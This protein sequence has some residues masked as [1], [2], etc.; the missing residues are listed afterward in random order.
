[1]GHRIGDR[2][3]VIERE[4]NTATGQIS[5]N[6]ELENLDE[7]QTDEFRREWHQ[8]SAHAGINHHYHPHHPYHPQIV[9]NRFYTPSSRTPS[10][11]LAIEHSASNRSSSRQHKKS[12][13]G[14]NYS[15]NRN[16]YS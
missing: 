15:S 10:A 5:E 9:S 13:K 11:P 4:M 12:S 7:E 3:H 14:F 16:P 2:K 8:R 6:V 1:M